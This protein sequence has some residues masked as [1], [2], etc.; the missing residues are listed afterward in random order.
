MGICLS[1]TV[2]G[3]RLTVIGDL[4]AAKYTAET[5]TYGLKTCDI[6]GFK[7]SKG[8]DPVY[9]K[10]QSGT[11]V[12]NSQNSSEETEA[13]PGSASLTTKSGTNQVGTWSQ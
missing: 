8:I 12:Q 13:S 6:I 4:V 9:V 5:S 3:P 1:L 11:F 10:V 7:N 2:I